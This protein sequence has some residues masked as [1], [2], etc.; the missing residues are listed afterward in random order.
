[1]IVKKKKK[2]T[3][4]TER[5]IELEYPFTSSKFRSFDSGDLYV[6]TNRAGGIVS[7]YT[8]LFYDGDNW[9]Y[10][11]NTYEAG[12]RVSVYDHDMKDIG[13]FIENFVVNEK[14]VY[15]N[16]RMSDGQTETHNVLDFSKT[17]WGG[18]RTRNPT[19]TMPL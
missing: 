10:I 9:G 6:R 11:R 5:K 13:G 15:A 2:M 14:S 12:E 16:L 3:D 4:I 1:V 8:D 18:V 19:P 7:V 17:K